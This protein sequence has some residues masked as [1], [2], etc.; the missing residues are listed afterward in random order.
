MPLGF[1]RM[2]KEYPAEHW[3]FNWWHKV[4]FGSIRKEEQISDKI[5]C[6]EYFCNKCK[7]KTAGFTH[8]GTFEIEITS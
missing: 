1:T 5:L 8:F 3:C 6:V 2:C 7:K 4:R